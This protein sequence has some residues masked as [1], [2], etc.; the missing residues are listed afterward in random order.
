[1]WKKNKKNRR[2]FFFQF[3]KKNYQFFFLIFFFQKKNDQI[4]EICLRIWQKILKSSPKTNSDPK[5]QITELGFSILNNSFLLT[6]PI[7]LSFLFLHLSFRCWFFLTGGFLPISI[8]DLF[9][10]GI[11]EKFYFPEFFCSRLECQSLIKNGDPKFL[12]CLL[13]HLR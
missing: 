5:Y 6:F 11:I 2:N 7:F 9:V 13:K 12:S 1:M 8:N 4:W 3:C 10:R